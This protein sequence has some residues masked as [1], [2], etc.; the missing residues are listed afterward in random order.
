MIHYF[1]ETCLN[2]ILT[3]YHNVLVSPYV[4]QFSLYTTILLHA[5]IPFLYHIA[6]EKTIG[7]TFN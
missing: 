2:Q 3:P 4:S 6:Y 1:Q 5:K 7:F